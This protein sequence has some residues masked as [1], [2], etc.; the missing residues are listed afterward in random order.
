MKICWEQISA[1]RNS[2]ESIGIYLKKVEYRLRSNVREN[3][4]D[5][6]ERI[7]ETKN[8]LRMIEIGILNK[9]EVF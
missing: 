1:E 7:E 4:K 5:K 8:D 2:E 3:Q 9:T 6:A